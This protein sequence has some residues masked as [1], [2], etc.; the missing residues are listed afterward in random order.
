VLLSL[1][2][3]PKSVQRELLS[4]PVTHGAAASLIETLILPHGVW[5]ILLSIVL[6]RAAIAGAKRLDSSGYIT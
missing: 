3:I 2:K 1:L 6:L 4:E 5:L